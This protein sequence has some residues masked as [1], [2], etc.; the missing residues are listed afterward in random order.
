MARGRTGQ[1]RR[2][3]TVT[4]YLREGENVIAVWGQLFAGQ[5]VNKGPDAFRS[6]GIALA[7]K[8]RFADGTESGFVTDGT[9]K[10][11][12]E[13]ADGWESPGFDDSRWAATTVAGR[14]GDAPWG[15]RV[16]E[17]VGFVTEPKRPLSIE[18]NSPYL[19][20]FDEVPGIVYDVKS[21][22]AAR[23]G[24]FRFDAPPGLKHLLLPTDATVQAWVNGKLANVRDRFV[25]VDEPP[26]KVSKVALRL[27]MKPGAYAGAAF[28]APIQIELDGGQIQPGPWS[29][30]ALP[31]YSG[32]GVYTQSFTLDEA[33]SIGRLTL[34][35]GEVL[36]AAEVFVNDQSAGTRLARPFS[37]D[38][39]EY[40]RK[41]ANSLRIHV[42]NT[43]AP[44]YLTI[45]AQNLGPVES[46]LLGPVQL[47]RYRDDA[48]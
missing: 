22:T 40:V 20:C 10:G 30:Y 45:P 33:D 21:E 26:I 48:P 14:M 25:T 43:I 4:P 29:D 24:W 18:L 41:G 44:H 34:D 46:G 47:M 3:F 42:A 9:W 16:V 39:T 13:D 28:T 35:L 5:N 11:S 23:V 31:T 1:N 32:I 8:M 38:L 36:V 19:T 37:F 12:M 2:V 6:R 7:F 15:M 27:D 17:N